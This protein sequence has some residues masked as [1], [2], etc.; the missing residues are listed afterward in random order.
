MALGKPLFYLIFEN[1]NT[2]RQISGKA[3]SGSKTVKGLKERGILVKCYSLQGIVEEAPIAYKDIN[4]VVNV[5]HQ[6]GLAKRVVRL[7]PL[8]VIKGE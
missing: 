1:K 2:R 4:D 7:M 6:A 5:V 8:A 3:I